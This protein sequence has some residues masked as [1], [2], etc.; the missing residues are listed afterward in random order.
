MKVIGISGSP[1][2]DSNTDRALKIA[3][4]ATG[5][6]TEFIKLSDYVYSPC[7]ACLGCEDTNVCVIED[8]ATDL[9]Q[10]VRSADA[11]IIAGYTPYSS[12]DGWTKSFLERLYQL[13]HKTGLMR[14]KPGGIII[15]SAIPPG[16]EM[17]PPAS[18]HAIE[19]VSYYMM[20]EGMEIMGSV[21]VMGNVP[22]IRCNH[23][24]QCGM[25]A[26]KMMFGPDTIRASIPIQKVEDQK[27][28]VS[29]LVALGKSIGERVQ[30]AKKE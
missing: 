11:V 29:G 5:V 10:K 17:L 14:E 25:S 20:E 3:L 28:V 7:R 19:S 15:T 24:E 8:D 13:R 18:K 4:N 6:E 21:C 23:E 1:I 16:N 12:L 26:V 30:Q 2:P 27:D 22:C 9:A